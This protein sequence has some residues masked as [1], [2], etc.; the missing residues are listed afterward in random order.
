VS[1]NAG[2]QFTKVG[3]MIDRFYRVLG[4]V[5]LMPFIAL[6]VALSVCSIPFVYIATGRGEMIDFFSMIFDG[7]K[8]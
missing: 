7:G 8:K 1:E 6:A 3:S 5:V 2:K 4:L